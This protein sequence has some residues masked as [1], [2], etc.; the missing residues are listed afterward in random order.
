[1]ENSEHPHLYR[2]ASAGQS[3]RAHGGCP[4][5][6]A[7]GLRPGRRQCGH[8][9]DPDADPRD[10]DRPC[11]ACLRL[12]RRG[13]EKPG[14]GGPDPHDLLHRRLYDLRRQ[15]SRGRDGGSLRPHG[16]PGAVLLCQRQKR[17]HRVG[18]LLDLLPA[19]FL[20]APAGESGPVLLPLLYG[21]LSP[22]FC[23]NDGLYRHLHDPVPPGHPAGK[24]VCRAA[25][26]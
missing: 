25:E 6:R 2:G 9:A 16:P 11:R 23:V 19:A 1:M 26:F 15:G 12:L 17:H 14:A 7:D 10:R 22:D 3:A 4:F 5:H 18:L 24:R 8:R 13:T 21:P 20:Y